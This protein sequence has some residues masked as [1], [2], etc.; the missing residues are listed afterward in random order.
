MRQAMLPGTD[1]ETL[2]LF[3]GTAMA[4]PERK[5]APP[6]APKQV[7]FFSC[8]RCFDTGTIRNNGKDYKCSCQD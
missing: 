6:K 3:S 5:E 1:L 7:S 2:P 8:P 4:E